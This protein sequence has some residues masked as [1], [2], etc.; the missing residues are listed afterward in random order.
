MAEDIFVGK[1][2]LDLA[3]DSRCEEEACEDDL[4]VW[5]DKAW[6]A[7]LDFRDEVVVVCADDG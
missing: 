1:C 3:D 7:E 2:L 5:T 4:V 6:C